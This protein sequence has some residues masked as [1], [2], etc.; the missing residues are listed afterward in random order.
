MS[1]RR[2]LLLANTWEVRGDRQD[3]LGAWATD[4]TAG[5]FLQPLRDAGWFQRATHFWVDDAPVA[6]VPPD[7]E[8]DELVRTWRDQTAAFYAGA[9]KEPRWKFWLSMRTAEAMTELTFTGDDVTSDLRDALAGVVA[10]W[11]KALDGTP[12]Q[13]SIGS[14]TPWGAAYD[15]PVPHR[16]SRWTLGAIAYYLG[17][18]WHEAD[19]ERAAV[20]D[21]IERAPLPAGI[22]R[23]TAG[24]LVCVTF[25]CDLA[26]P[27]SVAAARARGERWF[28]PLV[29][30]RVAPGWNA[31]GDRLVELVDRDELEP[32]TFFDTRNA[33]G[34]KAM[35]VDPDTGAVDD[36][37]WQLL[38]AIAMAGQAPDG[39]RVAAVRVIVPVRDDALRLA[40]RA[41][42]DGID[43]VAY[44]EEHSF[45]WI[46][47]A[48]QQG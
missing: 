38:V 26:D 47:P 9:E 30:T 17:R 29:P 3:L 46:D 37:L 13:A 27:A 31:R 25:D 19:P 43:L 8:L 4:A 42:A 7:A 41:R 1:D 5:A 18:A 48:A 32:F 35:V 22:S 21:A 36:E 28:A 44:P 45:W 40:D 23:T 14:L 33:T 2:E 39:T 6:P 24:D 15:R 12:L 20:L 34:Y 16:E 10:A 11:S